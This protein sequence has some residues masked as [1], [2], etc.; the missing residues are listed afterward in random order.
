MATSNVCFKTLGRCPNTPQGT[1]PLDPGFPP[2]PGGGFHSPLR[3]QG[4]HVPCSPAGESV[5]TLRLSRGFRGISSLAALP[6]VFHDPLTARQI[7]AHS[8]EN[9]GAGSKSQGGGKCS[10]P[11][12]EESRNKGLYYIFAAAA[13]GG[14]VS[15]KTNRLVV[16]TMPSTLR[17]IHCRD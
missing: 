1:L 5:G 3:Q 4:K 13:G 10:T 12:M 2:T 14:S 11:G 16:S 17:E 15:C 8:E 9:R 6:A 7:P